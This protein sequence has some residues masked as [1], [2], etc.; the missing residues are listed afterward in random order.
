MVNIR[1]DQFFTSNLELAKSFSDDWEPNVENMSDSPYQELDERNGFDLLKEE[2]D[3]RSLVE[4]GELVPSQ[5]LYATK[6]IGKGTLI[7]TLQ[8]PLEDL[9]DTG[10]GFYIIL[11]TIT[12]GNAE[13]KSAPNH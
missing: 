1:V 8:T 5:R 3:V 4:L 13:Q 10:L 12:F 7:V 6:A 9:S 11:E 2:F